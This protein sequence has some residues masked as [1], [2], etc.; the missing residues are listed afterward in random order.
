MDTWSSAEPREEGLADPK[1]PQC[2]GAGFVYPLSASG[3]PDFSRVV[4][5]RC[6]REELKKEKLSQ[7][8]QYSNLGVLS[9]LTF[10]SLSPAGR[11]GGTASEQSF[12]EAYEVAKA[13]ADDPQGWLILVGPNGCGKTHLACAI[14]NHRLGLG[15]VAFYIGVGDLLDHLRS[16]FSPSSEID[17]D[18]LFEQVKNTP[19]LVL[20]DLAM[21][22]TTPWA[23]GKMEQL[24]DYRFNT[25]LPTV[26][27]TDVPIEEFEENLQ[28]HFGDPRLCRICLIR[29]KSPSSLDHL[30]G[31][32]LELL[33][34]MTF[35]SFDYKRLNLPSEQRQNLEQA[36][37]R[38]CDFAQSPQDWLVFQGVNGCGKTHLAAAIA[39]HLRQ[40]G[41]PAL[42]VV[43][44]DL[45][46]HLRS[47]FGPESRVSYDELF[48]RIR[49]APVL[50]L[51][52]F[53]EESATPWAQE[54]L[55]QLINYRYNARLATVITT[56]LSLDEIEVRIS[57][58]LVDPSLSLVLN[59]MAPDYRGDTK[60]RRE[61][62]PQQRYP[63][64]GRL[65]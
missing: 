59:I 56:C 60:A 65:S 12:T 42:F 24:L 52:D 41:N 32:E 51:D 53:G 28:G 16:A 46:D 61:P 19:L 58:R 62:R 38:A 23:K 43:V 29:G 9:R 18:E 55:Y 50:I 34:R 21:T 4:P 39:N 3:R 31:L 25:R 47:T 27:T 49:K 44:P 35:E 30:G 17:Y 57:S 15:Q 54:K 13:F 63:R 48:E 36:Y 64:R 11:D 2:R 1:C 22:V 37:H 40:E 7:L 6:I 26:I 45:L 8:Q 33:R 20:D 14:A 10:D 5:C